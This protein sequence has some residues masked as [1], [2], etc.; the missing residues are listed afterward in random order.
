MFNFSLY[1]K[2]FQAIIQSF[3]GGAMAPGVIKSLIK[4]CCVMFPKIA[5]HFQ[6]SLL[7]HK[8]VKRSRQIELEEYFHNWFDYLDCHDLI[9]VLDDE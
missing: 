9:G 3:K 7:K 1:V 6:N 8:P 2:S 5:P 4:V